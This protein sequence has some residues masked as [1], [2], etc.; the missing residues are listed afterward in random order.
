MVRLTEAV[1]DA[2]AVAVRVPVTP[3]AGWAWSAASL[4]VRVAADWPVEAWS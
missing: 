4:V 2:A 1:T 3:A